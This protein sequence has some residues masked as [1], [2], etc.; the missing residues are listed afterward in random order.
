MRGD[1]QML[2]NLTYK[3]II[4]DDD[5]DF[6]EDYTEIIKKKLNAEGYFLNSQRF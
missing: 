6:Y 1:K 3:V 5:K 4:I 2:K